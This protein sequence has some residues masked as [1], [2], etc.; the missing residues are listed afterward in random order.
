MIKGVKIVPL[1]IFSDEKGSVKHMLKR[2]DKSFKKF[3]EVYFS[4]VLP[5]K[6]KAWHKSNKATKNYVVVEGNIKLVVYDGKEKQ[7]IYMGDKNYCLVT[8]PPGVWS[9][10]MPLGGKKAIV[11]NLMNIS[12]DPKDM[13]KADPNSFID[14]WKEEQ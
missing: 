6:V 10:F 11:C 4:E 13:M 3:G 14:C 8:I 1:K 9:G 12:F 2:T 7:E 5:G